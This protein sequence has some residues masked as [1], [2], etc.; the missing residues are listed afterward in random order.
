MRGIAASLCIGLLII[1]AFSQE[2][3]FSQYYAS[4]SVLNP[5]FIGTNPNFSFNTNYKRSGTRNQEAF[6]ELMQASFSYPLRKQTSRSFQTGAIG[7]TF[8]RESRGFEGIYTAQKILLTGAYAIKLSRLT[9]QRIIF[10]LQGGIVQNQISGD[11]FQWGS[12]FSQY[13]GF[14]RA[15]EGET[16][17][18]GAIYFPTANFGVIYSTFDNDNYMIRDKALLV[19]L[20]ADYLNEPRVRQDGFGITTRSRIFRA[21]SYAS[22]TLAPRLSLFPSGYVLYSDGNEQ[23]NAGMYLS[24]LVS[25]PRAINSVVLQVGSW[26]RLN[27]SIILLAG[28]KWNEI[29]LGMSVDLNTTSFDVNEALG[30]NLPSYEVSITYNLDISRSLGNVSSPIF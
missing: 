3:Q 17:G 27:D 5:A 12:Q 8:W 26:Y 14:D 4:S 24:S 6:L 10:G 13:I 11:N 20:S 30:N 21:F 18:T 22:F 2:G 19:G 23:V 25:L 15:R 9:N 29:R 7:A 16:V 1:R 28:M